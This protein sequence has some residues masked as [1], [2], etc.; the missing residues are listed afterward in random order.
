M[1][2]MGEQSGEKFR[3]D[4]GEVNVHTLTIRQGGARSVTAHDVT[5]RQGGI[6]RL[7]AHA[8][9]ITQGG[10][11]LATTERLRLTAGG[12]GAVLADQA[13]LEQSMAHVVAARERVDMDQAA[14]AVVVG[15]AVEVRDSAIGV[16]L[17]PNFRGQGVRVLMGPKAA[18][19]FGA[20]VGLVLSLVGFVRRRR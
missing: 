2:E 9:D 3:E 13:R 1:P 4:A 14:A 18:F 7:D 20:G 17:T 19:A 16:L 12:M 6:V 11:A 10:V 8:V 15:R 5:L